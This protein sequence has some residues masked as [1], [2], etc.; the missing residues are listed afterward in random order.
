MPENDAC[1]G[2]SANPTFRKHQ[3]ISDEGTP[4]LITKIWTP[5]LRKFQLTWPHFSTCLFFG[6][7]DR[8]CEVTIADGQATKA[9]RKKKSRKRKTIETA[10]VRDISFMDME[11]YILEGWLHLLLGD[12]WENQCAEDYQKSKSPAKSSKVGSSR[13]QSPAPNASAEKGR[14]AAYVSRSGTE[15]QQ[16]ALRAAKICL[17]TRPRADAY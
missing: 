6:L 12:S 7:L 11:V 9:R 13:P 4:R 1:A 16:W 14:R 15:S 10:K 2:V 17:E 3:I 5:L 8:L